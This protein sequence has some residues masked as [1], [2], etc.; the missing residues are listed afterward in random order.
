MGEQGRFSQVESYLDNRPI[1]IDLQHPTEVVWS[2][3]VIGTTVR[4]SSS[5]RDSADC[6]TPSSFESLI[7]RIAFGADNRCTNF[8]L[9]LSV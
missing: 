2:S 8:A 4:A 6:E 9:K 5:Q 3:F 1:E 7:A